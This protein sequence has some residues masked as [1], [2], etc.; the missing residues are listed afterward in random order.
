MRHKRRMPAPPPAPAAPASHRL[1]AI[2]AARGIAILAM[3]A[4]HLS[5]DLDAL[6]FAR[7]ALFTDP[8]W[9]AARTGILGSFLM[10]AGVSL[11]LAAGGGLDRRRFLRRLG[12]LAAAAAA[13]SAGSYVVFPDSPIFF[14]VLHH[15]AVASVLGLAFVRLPA[16]LTAALGIGVYALPEFVAVPLFDAPALRWIGLMTFEPDSNDYVPL[17]PWFGLVLLGIA[18]G[19][20]WR[21]RGAVAAWRPGAAGRA[22]AWAGRH[23]LPIYLVHQPVL[24]GALSLLAMLALDGGAETRAFLEACEARC[25]DAGGAPTTCAATCGCVADGA[26]QAG[27]WPELIASRLPPDSRARVA[28]LAQEC[29]RR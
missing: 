29:R 23:G 4:Y 15:L 10:L 26:K 9:L 21:G 20:V 3:I 16:G 24:Y 1:P 2:D 5:W 19:R 25:V 12:L 13:V 22:L 17:F 7:L 28:A 6:G 27:L 18:L 11:V 14:G 8:L